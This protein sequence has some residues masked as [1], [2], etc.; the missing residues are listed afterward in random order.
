MKKLF[1]AMFALVTSCGDVPPVGDMHTNSVAYRIDNADTVFVASYPQAVEDLP[2]RR[3]KTGEKNLVLSFSPSISCKL[4]RGSRCTYEV[5][6]KR[7][8]AIGSMALLFTTSVAHVGWQGACQ[9]EGNEAPHVLGGSVRLTR[10]DNFQH[11][12]GHTSEGEY[13]LNLS[14]GTRL[15]QS[16]STSDVGGGRPMTQLECY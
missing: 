8:G 7:S 14:D 4:L 10:H 15:K 11:G 13:S 5:H 2:M 16:F 1:W 3:W 12:V 9:G 6:T